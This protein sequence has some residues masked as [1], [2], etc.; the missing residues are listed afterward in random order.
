MEGN[1]E[2]TPELGWEGISG[3]VDEKQGEATMA[4]SITI[5][6]PE[7]GVTKTILVTSEASVIIQDDN[8]TMDYFMAITTTAKDVSGNAIPKYIIKTLSDGAGLASGVYGAGTDRKGNVLAG[9]K[10][11][12]LTDAIDD[13]VALMVEGK[14]N[15]PWTEMAFS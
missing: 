12:S 2:A 5:L 9:G 6:S 13:Y 4:T 3:S 10:Y 11:A 7:S 1:G 15:Q 14:D 8:G